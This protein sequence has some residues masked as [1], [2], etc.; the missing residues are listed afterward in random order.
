MGRNQNL[1]KQEVPKL[2]VPRLVARLGA[3]VD[4]RGSY[5]CDNV[6]VGGVV[7]ARRDEIWLL[8]GILNSPAANGIF[9]WLSKPFRGDYV[10]ANKQFIAPLPIPPASRAQRAALSGLAQGMQ[11]RITSQAEERARLEELLAACARSTLPLDRLLEDVRPLRE[12]EETVPRSL[13]PAARLGCIAAER[14]AQ[15]EAALARIDAILGPA[16]LL[17]VA[18]APGRLAFCVDEAEIARMFVTAEQ[19]PLVAAQWRATAIGFTPVG[20]GDADRLLERL[21]RLVLDADVAVREQI[22][23][24]GASLGRRAEVLRDDEEQLHELTCALFGLSEEER[25][26][27]ERGR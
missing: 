23:A 10:S 15:E 17:S 13:R 27:V 24:L 14:S 21:R 12:I 6:D 8:A 4:H 26:L 1:D 19:Q 20:K 2:L 7:P 25:R 22:V 5:Y 3:Y 11:Q 9:R 18:E 16:S